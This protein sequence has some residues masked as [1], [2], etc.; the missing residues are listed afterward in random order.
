MPYFPVL[1]NIEQ[2]DNYSTAAQASSQATQEEIA[3]SRAKD[4][5][6]LVYVSRG[7]AGYIGAKSAGVMGC[8]AS[9]WKDRYDGN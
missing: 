9:A 1:R 8:I 6:K 3:T 4:S 5:I 2:D 7:T